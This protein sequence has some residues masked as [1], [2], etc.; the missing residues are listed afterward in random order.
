M[1]LPQLDLLDGLRVEEER[2]PRAV[3]QAIAAA[4][5]PTPVTLA[6]AVLLVQSAAGRRAW[7][8]RWLA[9]DATGVAVAWVAY[10]APGIPDWM[11]LV[12]DERQA[13]QL[14][15]P[16]TPLPETPVGA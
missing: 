6:S 16:E 15:E 4:F 11:P 9:R 2:P 8:R 3:A 10:A 7:L 5:A 14:E 13:Y 12:D 1:S